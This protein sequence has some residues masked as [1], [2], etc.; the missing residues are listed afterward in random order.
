MLSVIDT[1]VLCVINKASPQA[2]KKCL[3]NAIKFIEDVKVKGIIVLDDQRLI[4]KEYE[5]KI[6]SHKQGL[7]CAFLK[8]IYTYF[9]NNNFCK[10]VEITPININNGEFIEFPSDERLNNF[11]KSDKKFIAVAYAY[12]AEKKP[13]IVNAADTDWCEVK[14]VLAE[15][16]I[17]VYFLDQSIC[18]KRN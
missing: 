15:H 13:C 2:S 6:D 3:E 4:L 12:P 9:K 17:N 14:D 8:W 16:G 18:N 10:I 1:N 11:D 7:G 5:S